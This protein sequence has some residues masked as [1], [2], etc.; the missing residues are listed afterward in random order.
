MKKLKKKTKKSV[1]HWL[2]NSL[3]V[4][5]FVGLSLAG[6]KTDKTCIA[7]LEYY[8][9]PGKIFLKELKDKINS[10][11]GKTSSDLELHKALEKIS[12]PLEMIAFD[13][14]LQLPKCIRCQLKCPGYD[15][16]QEPEI[17]WLRKFYIKNN[18]E[19]KPIRQFTP[20]TERCIENYLRT[21]LEEAFNLPHAL[22]ANAAPLTA[23]AHYLSRR[24]NVECIEVFTKLSLW[25]IG[26]SLG[27][28][29]S[30]L[31]YHKHSIE[32]ED[33]RE[34]IIKHLIQKDFTFIYSEDI[35]TLIAN[36]HAFDAFLCGLTAVLKFTQQ[37]E[38]RPKGFP[39]SESWIEIPKKDIIWPK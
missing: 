32:G 19:K 36:T 28:Q 17:K 4:H 30:Y 22:G 27:V 31:R 39:K 35:K 6:G 13:V 7:V 8:P 5:S 11:D 23:R 14:P 34:A 38:K 24:L 10:E 26:R 3:K 21:E 12:T 29:K 1:D 25:R 2:R 15:V 18:L 37:V 9:D 20:Y 16:C 33:I